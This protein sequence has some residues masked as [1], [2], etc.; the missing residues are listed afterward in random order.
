MTKRKL[1]YSAEWGD[2]KIFGRALIDTCVWIDL[3]TEPREQDLLRV[4]EE[5]VRDEFIDLI[6][7]QTVL[8]EWTRNRAKTLQKNRGANDGS[9]QECSARRAAGRHKQGQAGAGPAL[10]RPA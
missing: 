3:A 9:S 8:D 10:R 6:L 1:R 2:G 4:L 5:I 7:P